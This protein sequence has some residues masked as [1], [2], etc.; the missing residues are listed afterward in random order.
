MIQRNGRAAALV[1]WVFEIHGANNGLA[2]ERVAAGN[3]DRLI[4]R[5]RA[6]RGISGEDLELL[7]TQFSARR[8]R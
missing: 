5:S 1:N 3:T 4:L 7:L 6:E 8:C 2:G